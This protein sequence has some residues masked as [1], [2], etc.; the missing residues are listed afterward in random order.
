ME[1]LITEHYLTNKTVL[2]TGAAGFIGSHLVDKCLELGAIVIGVDNFITGRRINLAH[3][4]N[5]DNFYLVEADVSQT[6]EEYLQLA[7]DQL[8]ASRP[9]AAKIDV[10]FHLASPAS[11]VAYQ[12]QPIETYLVNS[13]GS[14]NLLSFLQKKYSKARFVFASTSEVYGDP[15]IHPQSEDYWGNVNPNGL[16]SCYDESKRLGETICGVFERQYQLDIRIARIFNTYGPRMRPDDG[17][18][19]PN[20]INQALRK[21]ALTVYGDGKQ[22]RAYCYVSDLVNGLIELASLDNLAGETINLGNPD[23]YT[24]LQTALLVQKIINSEIAKGDVIF[25]ELPSDDPTRRQPDISKAQ[26]LLNWQPSIEF[27]DGLAKTIEY[28]QS[29]EAGILE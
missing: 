6:S 3:L 10:L 13:I 1:D 2:I 17:R 27:R 15:E 5:Q 28:F 7:L 29:S 16:R 18:V 4:E 26:K 14:H 11:P 12:K 22:T 23:E 8:Q 19:L 9:E 24:V 25:K 21:E 20:F